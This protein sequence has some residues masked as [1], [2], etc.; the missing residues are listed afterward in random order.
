MEKWK[1]LKQELVGVTVAAL[2]TLSVLA[3]A[4]WI[5]DTLENDNLNT[6]YYEWIQTR[7]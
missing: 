2:V 7:R 3:F 5:I 1:R 6:Q 4:L